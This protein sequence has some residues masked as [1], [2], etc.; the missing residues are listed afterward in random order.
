MEK[1][2]KQIQLYIRRIDRDKEYGIEKDRREFGLV[3]RQKEIGINL[4]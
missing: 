4:D 1:R 2:Q 3:K